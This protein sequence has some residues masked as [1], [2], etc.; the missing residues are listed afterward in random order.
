MILDSVSNGKLYFDIL[1]GMDEV[2]SFLADCEKEPKSCG[3]YTISERVYVM[4]KSYE[5]EPEDHLRYETHEK[6][7]DVQVMVKGSE[8]MGW[9]SI[10]KKL[11][12]EPY[13][14]DND[15]TF[16]PDLS[17]Q[18]IR[19]DAGEFIVF[20]PDDAHKPGCMN[21]EPTSVEKMVFKVR[22]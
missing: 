5:T 16:Y 22:L 6:W 19:V 15:V 10:D 4:V 1:P 9:K 7:A 2:F 18:N 20:F 13:N 3:T 17:G 21:D 8:W 14:S 12:S 11:Y